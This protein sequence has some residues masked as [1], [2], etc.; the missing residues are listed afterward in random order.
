MN[1]DLTVIIVEYKNTRV[2]RE[3]VRSVRDCVTILDH[4]IIVISN[5]SYNAQEKNEFLRDFADVIV[6]FNAEN[7]GFAKAVNQG[8]KVS[9]SK[10]ILLLNPDAKLLDE[11]ISLAINFMDNHENVGIAGPKTVDWSGCIQDS[12]R[13]FLTLK[14]LFERTWKRIS[15]QTASI[16]DN[17]DYE[18]PQSVDWVSGGCMLVRRHAIEEV[19]LLDERYFMYL[20]DMDWCRRFWLGGWKVWY[21]PEWTV[22]HT[23]E[24]GSTN[25]FNIMNRLMWI[26]ISSFCKYLLKW[27]VGF[28]YDVKKECAR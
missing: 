28:G 23:G 4:E 9:K 26:H 3:A 24:R 12:C 20:E 7:A 6:I 5:S 1:K 8:I 17:M 10:F 16:L 19:G 27:Q 2:T 21:L 14:G 11:S 13:S 22:E 25:H 18:R 15:K